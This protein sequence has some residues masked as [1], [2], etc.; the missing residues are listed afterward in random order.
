MI[1]WTGLAPREVE[2]PFPGSLIS[3]FLDVNMR[4]VNQP[5][6]GR[7]SSRGATG[8][9]ISPSYPPSPPPPFSLSPSHSLSL[10]LSLSIFRALSRSRSL[11]LSLPLSRALSVLKRRDVWQVVTVNG[12]ENYTRAITELIPQVPPKP[13][14]G[15]LAHKQQC[16]RGCRLC[17]CSCKTHPEPYRGTSLIRNCHPHRTTIGP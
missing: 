17:N 10:Y 7:A 14:Q 5:V 1:M 8:F 12:T 4:I 3:T 6:C 13:I 15:H 9:S 16:L 11:Y 2:F